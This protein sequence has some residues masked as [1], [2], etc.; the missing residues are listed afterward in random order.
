MTFEQ[1]YYTSCR[2][3]RG[4]GMGF[5]IQ[6]ASSGLNSNQ[7]NEIQRLGRYSPPALSPDRP[8]D[9]EL[10]SEVLFPVSFYYY[11]LPP[12]QA[13][14]GQARYTGKDYSNRFGN[15]FAHT[16]LTTEPDREF[17][18][19]HPIELW[20]ASFW[21]SQ[22]NDSATLP[23]LTLAGCSNKKIDIASAREFVT[24]T[25]RVEW[26]AQFL[27]ATELALTSRRRIIIVAEN[28]EAVA[29]WISVAVFLLPRSL[30]LALTFNTYVRDPYTT[31]TLITGITEQSATFQFS[32][33]EMQ[34]GQFSVFDFRFRRFSPLTISPFGQRS[35]GFYTSLGADAPAEFRR[36]ARR[37]INFGELAAAVDKFL[38]R[39]GQ[40]LQDIDAAAMLREA[41]CDLD[42]GPNE[43]EGLLVNILP[44]AKPSPEVCSAWVALQSAFP[45][46]EKQP[47]VERV[48]LAW[49]ANWFAEINPEQLSRVRFSEQGRNE[50]V[51][52]E[53][54]WRAWLQAVSDPERLTGWLVLALQMGTIANAQVLEAIG[55]KTLGP[56]LANP[57]VQECVVRLAQEKGGRGVVNGIARC[58]DSQVEHRE[59]FMSVQAVLTNQQLLPL[60]E[61]Y[62]LRTPALRL[63]MRLYGL[64]AARDGLRT[65]RFRSLLETARKSGQ[66]SRENI[67]FAYQ[68]FWPD[69]FPD[70]PESIEVLEA[71]RRYD[72]AGTSVAT[73]I[74]RWLRPQI[75]FAEYDR[76]LS[77][78]ACLLLEWRQSNLSSDWAVIELYSK[79]QALWTGVARE[80]TYLDLVQSAQR[81]PPSDAIQA[82]YEIFRALLNNPDTD[83]HTAVLI[84]AFAR[85][86]NQF[87]C[88]YAEMANVLLGDSS[89]KPKL[90]SSMIVAWSSGQAR[91]APLQLQ[92]LS[93]LIPALAQ[94]LS[95]KDQKQVAKLLEENKVALGMWEARHEP[96]PTETGKRGFRFKMPWERR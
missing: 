63:L 67:E 82:L 44:K 21:V 70:T 51:L 86:D 30:S 5:Q 46:T 28:T 53:E 1:A 43:L 60:F 73:Q 17:V 91:F 25:G 55:E 15:F 52:Q 32:P 26:L 89:N 54:A 6:A 18:G 9:E 12:N 10:A 14:V 3:G 57:R 29:L 33:M 16:L 93:G 36:F 69:T 40:G 56:L 95:G 19:F 38:F 47:V 71:L 45:G 96:E 23:Q 11:R 64:L 37:V 27:T 83:L 58:L 84:A 85:M 7:L 87:F 42:E 35:T 68:S 81:L 74:A 41:A 78:A 50:S 94:R 34:G 22:G 13:V 88:Q 49:I 80:T 65:V 92:R 66:L 76:D 61:E 48:F 90:L 31:D 59:F 39:K 24:K 20:G 75:S 4:S 77:M 72:C 79:M 8:T 62:A 2:V